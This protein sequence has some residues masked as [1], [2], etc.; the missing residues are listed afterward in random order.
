MLSYQ[1]GWDPSG[2]RRKSMTITFVLRVPQDVHVIRFGG[3]RFL[4]L[5]TSLADISIPPRVNF[6]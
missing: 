1:L 4:A 3:S 2:S 5:P 6:R